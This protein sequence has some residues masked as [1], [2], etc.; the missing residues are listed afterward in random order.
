MSSTS[1]APSHQLGPGEWMVS[2][3]IQIDAAGRPGRWQ[4]DGANGRSTLSSLVLRGSDG[5]R[6][7]AKSSASAISRP[8]V[9]RVRGA[10][11]EQV[12]LRRWR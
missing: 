10:T 11:V 2:G 3:A 1:K 6:A 4:H 5:C 12:R 9:E 7:R 8:T